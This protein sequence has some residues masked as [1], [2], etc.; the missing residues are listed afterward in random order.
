MSIELEYALEHKN[1]PAVLCCRMEPGEISHHNLE[2]P[3]IFPDL[4]DTGLL[5]LDGC[6]TI[7]QCLGATLK[8]VSDSLTPLTAEIVDNIQDPAAGEEEAAEEAPA[9]AAAPALAV[10]AG[11]QMTFGGGVVK[12]Y[13]AEGKDIAIEFPV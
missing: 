2:D 13:I 5:K 9:E 4:V 8:E 1:D 11:T 3:A 7:G 12:L 10:P 6:L